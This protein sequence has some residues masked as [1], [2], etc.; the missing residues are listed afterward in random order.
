MTITINET[1]FYYWICSII[2]ETVYSYI[3]FKIAWKKLKKKSEQYEMIM[4]F[5]EQIKKLASVQLAF[6]MIF[7]RFNYITGY[8]IFCILSP[9]LAPI[10]LI[11]LFKKIVGYKTDLEK[12]VI[13]E[14]KKMEEA[15]RKSKEWMETEGVVLEKPI[16]PIDEDVL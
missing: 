9:L 3:T 16:N 11:R 8:L 5:I 10:S 6:K 4:M 2:F 1:F 15:E 7:N 12:K 13:E 14:E